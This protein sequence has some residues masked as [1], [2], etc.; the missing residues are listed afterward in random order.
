MVTKQEEILAELKQLQQGIRKLAANS[1]PIATSGP[2][3]KDL[4]GY[5][6]LPLRTEEEL[7]QTEKAIGISGQFKALV[8]V[9]LYEIIF[10]FISALR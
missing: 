2:V 1:T 7:F 9:Y 8:K 5:P 10:M 6:T 4:H 3:S